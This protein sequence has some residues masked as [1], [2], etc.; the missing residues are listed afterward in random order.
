MKLATYRDGSRD[1]QLVVVS[2][3]LRTAHFATGIA[4]RLQQVLDDWNFLSPQLQDLSVTL[5]Q[6][7]ARHAFPFEPRQ[8]MAPLPRAFGCV[9]AAPGADRAAAPVLWP[10][11]GDGL[12]GPCQDAWL[13][14]AAWG[15]AAAPG[16]AV[17]TGDIG[18]GADAAQGLDGVRLLLL[19]N[20]WQLQA[21][22]AAEAAR[23]AP[24]LQ[25]LPAAAFG[26]VAVTPDELGEAWSAG[27]L[28]LPLQAMLNGRRLA[29][30]EA[31][32]AMPHGFG[33]LLAHLAMTRD[34][35]AGQIVIGGALLTLPGLAVGDRVGIDMDGLDGASVF[36]AIA[37]RVS[38]PQDTEAD[39][40]ADTP[41]GDADDPAAAG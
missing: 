6:G 28:S 26:P 15:L 14:A 30:V 18:M 38:G 23:G 31:A 41:A 17:V 5:N 39:T 19:A 4:T 27:R 8:C 22:A 34:L 24:P 37:Q 21:L 25:G 11:A 13:G 40:Q 16:L 10:A 9:V 33:A 32:P 20:V 35:H 2:R 1:G 3:D 7:R 12:R 29:P 36:G